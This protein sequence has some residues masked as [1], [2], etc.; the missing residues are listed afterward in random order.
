MVYS[1]LMAGEGMY[2]EGSTVEVAA[3]CVFLMAQVYKKISEECNDYEKARGVLLDMTKQAI[4]DN[5]KRDDIT[6]ERSLAE[7]LAYTE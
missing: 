4:Y 3:E 6:W 5:K 7:K 2:I 1:D